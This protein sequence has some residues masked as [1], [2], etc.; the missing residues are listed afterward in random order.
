MALA[1]LVAL[2]P[3]FAAAQVSSVA[4]TVMEEPSLPSRQAVNGLFISVAKAGT[5]LAAAGV[6]GR[7][8]LSDDNGLSW[9]QVQTPTS[10][11]LTSIGFATPSAGWAVGQMGV[12]LHTVDGGAH[13]A[14][15]FDGFRANA[16]LL[17]TAQA[18]AAAHPGNAA[19]ATNVQNAQQFVSGGPSVP[20]LAVL[21]LSGTDAIIA[22]GF[23]MAFE[24]KDGG[25]SWQSLFDEVPN[26]NGLNIYTI[27]QDGAQQF[28]AGEQGLAL[29]RDA[30]GNFKTLAPPFQGTFFGALRAPDG[31]L[32]LYGLQGTVL[33]SADDGGH[34]S[35]VPVASSSGVD[36]GI[37]L[38]NGDILL[39][40]V[41]GTL[42]LSKDGGKSFSDTPVGGPVAG[43]AQAADGGVITAGPQGLRRL[44]P[45]FLDL[46]D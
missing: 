44:A 29:M 31:T 20:F 38:K 41:D 14:L 4:R 22:G 3:G 27:I 19:A 30:S 1:L 17:A 36:C 26:P 13:W 12:V 37:V 28:W 23:G 24:T 45:S 16:S 32:L 39:G 43:L 18:D 42:L 15:Q 7:I 6:G 8:L 9:R 21:P 33:R 40:D 34:W 2:A 25:A 11:T 10:V 35:P 5:R 46:M